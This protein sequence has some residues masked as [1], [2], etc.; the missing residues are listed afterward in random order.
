M[1]KNQQAQALISQYLKD[2]E[3]RYST[4]PVVNRFKVKWGMVD[5]IDSVGYATA[6]EL[7]TY[8]FKCDA[9]HN[10]QWFL[11]NFDDLLKMKTEQEAD[12]KK[13]ARLREETRR[14]MMNIE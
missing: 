10:V 5:V 9:E 8:Y 2:Y 13:R 14:R 12:E 7:I 3:N 1:N 4:V 6:K 11:N